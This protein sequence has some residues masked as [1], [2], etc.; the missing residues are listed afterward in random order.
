[1]FLLCRLANFCEAEEMRQMWQM[2]E[3]AAPHTMC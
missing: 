1:M 2:N 3:K